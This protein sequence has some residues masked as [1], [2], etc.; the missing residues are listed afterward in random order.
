MR[1]HRTRAGAVAVAT[2][3]AAALTAGLTGPAAAEGGRPVPGGAAGPALSAGAE[4][5]G[6]A[7][8]GAGAGPAQRLTLVTGDRVDVD[9]AGR[10]TGFRPAEGR[11]RIP[12]HT[13]TVG[14]RTLVLPYDARRL[15]AEGR[16]DRR[17]FDVTELS[18]EA[19]RTP[20]QQ[21]LKLIVGYEGPARGAR[22]G[23]R[24][25]GDT[26]VRRVLP[27]LNAEA[28]RTPRRD[29]ALLWRTLTDARGYAPGV[30]RLWLDGTREATLDKSVPQIGAPKVW[31]SG[32]DG[33]GVT[34]AVLDSGVDSAHPDLKDQ[35][36]AEKNFS[37][38]PDVEDRVGHGTHVASTAAGTGAASGGKLKG[39][40]PGAKVL[41]GKVLDD[42][43]FGDDSG[44]VAGMEWAAAQGADVVNLSLGG[45]D[46][47]GT[48][49]L[50]AAVDR[51]S[52]DKGVLFAV[53]AGN[54]GESGPGTI[55]SPG[56][57]KAALTVGAVDGDDKLADFSSRGPLAGGGTVKP[58][59]TA[60]GVDITAAAAP[61][62]QIE[63]Q[64]GQKPD[65]YLTISGTSMAAPHAAGA[66][67]LLKQRHPHWKH[68]ELKGALTA[69]ARGG[70][71]SPFEQGAGRIAVDRAVD[72]TVIA[73]PVSLDFGKQLWPHADDKPVTKKVTY[74]NLGDRDV[75]LDLAVTATDPKGRPAPAGFF[76]LGKRKLTVPAGGRAA[77]DLVADTR[78]GGSVNGTYAAYVTATGG[79]Q[80]VRTAAVV[81][82][83]IERYEVTLRTVGRDGRPTPDHV[84]LLQG[85]TGG[86]KG[87]NLWPQ[88]PSGTVKVRIAKGS[89]LLDSAVYVDPDNGDKGIDWL[90]QPKLTV[91]KKMTVTL[92]AR[93]AKPVDIT[94]PDPGAELAFLDA[95][96]TYAGNELGALDISRFGSLRTAHLG[97]AV[98][99]G[100]GQQWLGTWRKGAD[101]RYDVMLG[102]KVTKFATGYTRHLRKADFAKLTIRSGASAPGR[103]GDLSVAGY[104]PEAG[105]ISPI[106]PPQRLPR[107]TTAYVSALDGAKWGVEFSQYGDEDAGGDRPLESSY[108]RDPRAF[109][110]GKAYTET[111]NT[112]V[113]GPLL[114]PGTGVF[115]KGD[116]LRGRIPVVADGRGHP[117]W[118]RYTAQKSVL[119]RDGV[120]VAEKD[121]A[122]TGAEGFKVPADDAE[123]R[124]TASVT[125]SPKLAA[126]SSR[127]EASWTFR[128]RHVDGEAA[129]PVSTVRFTPKLGLDSRAPA[130][131]KQSVPVTVQ[132]HAAGGNLAS[133][134]AYASYDKGR[135]WTELTVS[136]GKAEVTNPARG[137]G[138]SFR[139]VVTDRQGNASTVT[140]LDAYL[141]R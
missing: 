87:Q 101:Q 140:V 99:G 91:N 22:A 60:P 14:G 125:R 124:L 77:V 129:L 5:V 93:R 134:T 67:A 8:N 56:S 50:E 7:G 88:S 44:I 28:V 37:A 31:R 123:Y 45:G 19:D 20:R 137:K 4:G 69:S 11:E 1:H 120:K 61:G 113:F 18:R 109:R 90:V 2:A 85:L 115:R 66:A 135:T 104:L 42:E 12:V 49:P 73:R 32:Y 30:R 114:G 79:G 119:Y 89:Y 80:S 63:K 34:I 100:F 33:K 82:R 78:P 108:E 106:L 95:R 103:W 39:V 72:Q 54:N 141:G 41:S 47:E 36:V 81:E 133:L 130:G 132:G 21:G 97:P 84:T 53:S 64:V 51:L 102:G 23:V 17:L 29:A 24:A 126:V 26:T 138:V 86:D 3:V 94:V 136:G 71:Y 98:P 25:A 112:G 52:A 107:T 58:D 40:A 10:V 35:V 46:S 13:Q 38:A 59:V 48:D 127:V 16:V 122:V 9:A 111:F 65:G 27:S 105:G 92:D 128:S 74:E 83:E 116:E 43:G 68:T 62:S 6:G 139:A 118:S 70:A 55:G 121:D 76:A 15:V 75:T 131:V 57:A 96:Y 117:G 110:A